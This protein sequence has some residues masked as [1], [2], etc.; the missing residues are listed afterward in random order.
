MNISSSLWFGNNA[1]LQR[2][3]V[4]LHLWSLQWHE[5]HYNL[6]GKCKLNTFFITLLYENR[7][8]TLIQKYGFERMR[9]Y[10]ELQTNPC[11]THTRVFKGI[12]EAHSRLALRQGVSKSPR[13][14]RICALPS[15]GRTP[16]PWGICPRHGFCALLCILCEAYISLEQSSLSK[17]KT[18]QSKW[19]W[20]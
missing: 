4:T 5:H 9:I 7:D 19:G 6:A 11:I 14:I 8:D 18:K 15:K 10:L 2:R 1:Y 16:C 17:E 13:G 20:T 3:I 12:V